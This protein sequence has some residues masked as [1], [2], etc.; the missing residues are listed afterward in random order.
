MRWERWAQR[1]GD[2]GEP[3]ATRKDR[4]GLG[5]RW[6][7]SYGGRLIQRSSG[8][9]SVTLCGRRDAG[10]CA[11]ELGPHFVHK[12]FMHKTSIIS[13]YLHRRGLI[14]EQ[15]HSPKFKLLALSKLS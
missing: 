9:L 8:A 11:E 2:G 3:I 13:V 15:S 5:N 1:N 4:R 10:F 7:G 14:L 6:G 12:C